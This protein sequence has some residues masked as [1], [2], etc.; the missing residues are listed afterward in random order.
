MISTLLT[1][2][3]RPPSMIARTCDLL[4]NLRQ[5]PLQGFCVDIGAPK[6]VVGQNQLKHT[7]QYIGRSSIPRMHSNNTY[8]F[9]DVTVRTVGTVEIM[10]ATP[11]TVPD[12][13]VLMDIVPVNVPALLGLDILDSE[14]LY[15]DNVTNRLVH[16]HVVSNNNGI[17][18]YLDKWH[19]PL[20]RHDNHLYAAMSFP[21]FLFYTTTQLEKMHRQFAHPSASKLF[22][23]LK[24]AGTEA[25]DA[26]TFKRIRDIVARCEPCQ[27]IHNAPVRFR[28]SIG[29]E[30]VRFNARAYIDIMYLD[31]KPVLHI[32]DEA[33]RFSAAR[34]LP[35]VSTDAVWDSLILCWSSVYT[36]LPHHVMVDEGSQFRKIFAELSA[37]HDVKL[38]QSGVQS[39]HSLGI[40]ERYHKPYATHTGN[41]SWTTR[42]C[43]DKSCSPL[44]SKR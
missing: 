40:G 38:E 37:L 12:I 41:L 24:R 4:P 19:V 34:F 28:V 30:H 18:Q 1:L 3:K 7:L 27:R 10:L 33:T 43:N 29:H 42:P 11:P 16:R 17:L 9:G 32:V 22:N 21:H 23:L 2:K 35:K 8:R 39:H 15:A 25:V 6:S 13:P 26:K 14:E 31:G 5:Q 36:G 44:P 20:S